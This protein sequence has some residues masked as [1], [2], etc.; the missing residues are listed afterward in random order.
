MREIRRVMIGL[1]TACVVQLLTAC[2]PPPAT[3]TAPAP[4][5]GEGLK[6]ETVSPTIDERSSGPNAVGTTVPATEDG[7]QDSPEPLWVHDTADRSHSRPTAANGVIYVGLAGNLGGGTLLALDQET[8]ELLWQYETTGP[9]PTSPIVRDDVVYFTDLSGSVNA[10]D[11]RSGQ[12]IWVSDLQARTRSLIALEEGLLYVGAYYLGENRGQVFAIDSVTGATVWAFAAEGFFFESSPTVAGQL[13]LVGNN[14]G[15]LYALDR[16]DGSLEWRYKA[17]DPTLRQHPLSHRRAVQS[18]AV[19][20]DR[21]IYLSTNEGFV[22]AI[23]LDSQ[24]PLWRTEID[25]RERFASV[26]YS[27]SSPAV[28]DSKVFVGSNSG[29]F[30]ALDVATG[31]IVWEF[32]TDSWIWSTPAYHQGVVYFGSDDNF[33]YALDAETGLVIWQYDTGGIPS[34]REWASGIWG[35]PHVAEAAVYVTSQNG[36]IHA[37]PLVER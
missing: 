2:A 14:D 13:I 5:A 36:R 6:T 21:V 1:I 25:N 26:K 9:I 30:Y 32:Q 8:G 7:E 19:V 4:G 34:D 31:G 10:L 28:G 23:R 33:L 35:D 27:I 11:A 17:G 29:K 24:E 37:L 22:E 18:T 15:Y 12:V 3:P 16:L 20:A